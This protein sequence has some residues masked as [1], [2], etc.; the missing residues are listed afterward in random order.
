MG[1]EQSN[2][3]LCGA[4]SDSDFSEYTA[5]VKRP[6]QHAPNDREGANEPARLFLQSRKECKIAVHWDF[7]EDR[8]VPIDHLVCAYLDMLVLE[9]ELLLELLL[10]LV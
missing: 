1:A 2:D 6:A 5:C 10:V 9:L 4:C 8:S 3:R 7:A